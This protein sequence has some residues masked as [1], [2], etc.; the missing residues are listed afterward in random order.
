MAYCPMCSSRLHVVQWRWITNVL[1]ITK[2]HFIC[3]ACK[4]KM[5]IAEV[6]RRGGLAR[7]KQNLGSRHSPRRPSRHKPRRKP[8]HRR[9]RS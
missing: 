2:P 1:G 6:H 8:T 7:I 4:W 5:T 3:P 9:R